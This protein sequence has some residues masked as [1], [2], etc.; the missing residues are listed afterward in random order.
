MKT[1]QISIYQFSELSDHAK[2]LAK[3]KFACDEGYC[4]S[5][6][7][8]DS[9]KALAAHFS[10]RVKDYQLDWF[11]SMPSSMDFD[12][13]DMEPAEIESRLSKLGT[14]NPETLRGNG[15]C[16]LTGYCGDE[17][18]IDAFRKAWNK[19]EHDLTALMDAAYETWIKA[20]QADCA[21][22]YTDEQFGEFCD[23]NNYEFYEDGEMA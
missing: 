21:S 11:D 17:D 9:I 1:K 16:K 14:F 15:D 12:M 4:W 6:E 23:S 13:P 19:G 7:M 5:A 20:A 3:D 18:A 22:Q 10:G 2:Q 8:L